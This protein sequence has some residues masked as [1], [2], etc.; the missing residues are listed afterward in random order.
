M[1]AYDVLERGE[2]T[3]RYW[4]DVGTLDTYYT[5]NMELLAETP[6]FDLFAPD[7]PIRHRGGQFPPTLLRSSGAHHAEVHDSMISPGCTVTGGTIRRSILSPGVHVGPGA[8]VEASILMPG[9]RVGAGAVVERAVV[10]ENVI[11]PSGTTIGAADAERRH[12]VVTEGGIT[13]VPEGTLIG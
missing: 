10:D 12:F 11:V 9:V 1:F 4:Q 8:R 2:P 13:V 7:W 5:T 6:S 3:E